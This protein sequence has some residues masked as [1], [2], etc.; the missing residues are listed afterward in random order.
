MHVFGKVIANILETLP[1]VL[2]DYC[3]VINKVD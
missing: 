2:N 1:V 3:N